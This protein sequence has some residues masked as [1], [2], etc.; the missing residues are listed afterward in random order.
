VQTLV[1]E[2]VWGEGTGRSKQAA[3]QAAARKALQV[4]R[5]RHTKPGS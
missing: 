3:E 5:V 1:G 4:F 2:D